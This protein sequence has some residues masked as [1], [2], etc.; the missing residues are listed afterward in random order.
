MAIWQTKTRKNYVFFAGEADN[1]VSSK[2]SAGFF[3]QPKN[4][5][6]VRVAATSWILVLGK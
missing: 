2:G 6:N 4:A 3:F 5:V 1:S